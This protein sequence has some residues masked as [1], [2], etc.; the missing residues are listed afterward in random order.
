MS[1]DGWLGPLAQLRAFG[2]FDSLDRPG[3]R[4]REDDLLF[5]L[6]IVT[7]RRGR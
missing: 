1:R 6:R 2:R 3:M 4:V 7:L 5:A